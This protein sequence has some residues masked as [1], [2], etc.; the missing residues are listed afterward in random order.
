MTLGMPI[1][2][3]VAAQALALVKQLDAAKPESR[4]M[5]YCYPCS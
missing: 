4:D 3:S 5:V 1:E 2:I